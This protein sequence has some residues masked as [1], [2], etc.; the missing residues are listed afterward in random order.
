MKSIVVSASEFMI[1][2]TNSIG[3]SRI[4]PRARARSSIF[5]TLAMA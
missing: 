1:A 5:A 3:A 2:T 4:G